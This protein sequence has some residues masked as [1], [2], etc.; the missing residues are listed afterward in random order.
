MTLT[1]NKKL[2]VLGFLSV[3]MFSG[4]AADYYYSDTGSNSIVEGTDFSVPQFESQRELATKL[5]APFI[6]IAILLQVLFERALKFAFIDE[7]Q[8]RDLFD[9]MTNNEPPS[10]RKESTIMALAV[11]ALLIPTPFWDY[12]IFAAASIPVVAV[13]LVAIAFLYGA[14]KFLSAL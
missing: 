2:L 1:L 7:D 5:V 9:M 11:T 13:S 4:V 12:V 3:I 10:V 6:F 14:Y 8:N